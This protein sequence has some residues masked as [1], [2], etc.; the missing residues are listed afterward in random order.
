[1]SHMRA[2]FVAAACCA[3][4]IAPAAN[5]STMAQMNAP[6]VPWT[7]SGATPN[8]ERDAAN[9]VTAISLVIPGATIK[10]LPAAR[11]EAVYPVSGAG[12]VQSVNL[13]WHPFGHEPE[14]VYDVPHFDVHFYTIAEGVRHGI[15]PGAAAGKVQPAKRI[16]P[17]GV[18]LAPGY[19]PMMGMHAIPLTQ[20]EFKGG[21]FGISPVIGYWNGNLAFFEVMFS[22]AWL[23]QKKDAQGAYPQPATAPRHGAYPTKYAVHYDAAKDTYT[24][25]LTNFRL[26]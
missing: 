7:D 24:V 5:A 11:S 10:S 8:V 1:M 12:L 26:R 20:P 22:K 13:Q 25:A 9:H 19:V 15:V 17:P 23:E 2:A 6:P 18:M 3:V 21:T 14:H 4:A 16:M